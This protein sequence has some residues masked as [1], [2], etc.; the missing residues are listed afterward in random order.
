MRRGLGSEALVRRHRAW[1]QLWVAVTA[2]VTGT[3][4]LWSSSSVVLFG[5]HKVQDFVVDEL[6]RTV[7]S[8]GWRA[9]SAPRTYWPPPPTESGSNGYLRVRCNGGLS[10]QRSAICNV[11]ALPM[12]SGISLKRSGQIGSRPMVEKTE[13][14]DEPLEHGLMGCS[15]ARC[16]SSPEGR[17]VG[18][19]GGEEGGMR[20]ACRPSSRRPSLRLL[21]W[22]STG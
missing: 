8:N 18:R 12:D 9:S 5:T 2:L 22:R 13:Y 19:R 16:R 7:D 15:C 21:R 20:G 14:R 1:V 10:Q 11:G 6:W 17:R 4:W 3:I